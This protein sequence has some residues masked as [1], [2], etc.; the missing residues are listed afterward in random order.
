MIGRTILFFVRTFN[1]NKRHTIDN[2]CNDTDYI[3][4]GII[5]MRIL[6]PDQRYRKRTQLDFFLRNDGP[7]N[8]AALEFSG[9]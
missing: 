4:V 5:D 1:G 8:R 6:S 9:A 3:I 7:E 2:E